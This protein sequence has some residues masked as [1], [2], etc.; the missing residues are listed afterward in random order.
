MFKLEDLD[1]VFELLARVGDAVVATVGPNCEVVVHDL[2]TP[3]HAVVAISGNLTRR[4]VGSPIPDPE[5]L[6]ENVNRFET[7]LLLYSTETS[8]GKKLLSSTVWVRDMTGSIVGALCINM[9]FSDIQAA[10]DLLDRAL[11]PQS[12]SN[13]STISTFATSPEEFV[14]VALNQILGDMRMEKHQLEKEDK[15]ALISRLQDAGIFGLRRASELVASELGI[16]R[17]SVYGYLKDL[18]ENPDIE[19][20]VLDT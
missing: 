1:T 20:K 4:A 6:P 8:F 9:D 15:L 11:Q 16:S 14:T 19:L 3:D 18:R 12:T 13:G 5:L 17:A 7:D 10:R 2:R